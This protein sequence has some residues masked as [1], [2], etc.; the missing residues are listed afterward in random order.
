MVAL[1]FFVMCAVVGSIV[2]TAATGVSGQLKTMKT[3]DVEYYSVSSA[4]KYIAGSLKNYSLKIVTDVYEKQDGSKVITQEKPLLKD[5]NDNSLSDDSW[6]TTA[7]K[8]CFDSY[9]NLENLGDRA[10]DFLNISIMDGSVEVGPTE[11]QLSVG[12]IEEL[13]VIVK[14]SMDNSGS[15]TAYV[16]PVN[17]KSFFC[18]KVDAAASISYD[19][20]TTVVTEGDYRYQTT[21]T[22]VIQYKPENI[23]IRKVEKP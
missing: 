12:E 19:D 18:L 16:Y 4:S 14:L 6:L 13:K 9:L 21:R 8:R 17:N 10:D 15:I 23:T 22:Y 2:M 1:L 5:G 11:M 7:I 20:N 3:D